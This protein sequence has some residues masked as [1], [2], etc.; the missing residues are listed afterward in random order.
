MKDSKTIILEILI[1]LA[2]YFNNMLGMVFMF[3][4]AA[5]KL[6]IQ[7]GKNSIR[8]LGLMIMALP[9]AYI[10][11]AGIGMHQLFSWYNVFLVCFLILILHSYSWK[12]P[13]HH[14]A[15][16]QLII[17]LFLLL[18]N[19]PYSDDI[20]QTFVEIAQ[21]FVMLIPIVMLHSVKRSLQI[22]TAEA[23]KLISMYVD[24]C[25]ATS[26]AMLVQYIFYFFVHIQVGII[27]VYGGGRV[28]C[29]CLFKGASILPV[30]IG[31]GMVILFLDM[32]SYRI[33][34][35]GILKM[36]VLFLAVI[37]NSSR[38]ALFALII[39]LAFVCLRQLV[40]R[41]GLK[42][43][44]VT[45]TGFFVAA[46]GVYY[47]ISLRRGL[48]GFLDANGRVET[49]INGI[50]IW[51]ADIKNFLIGG[52]LSDGLW[53]S[54]MEPHNFP[55]QTL[56]QSGLIISLIIFN[57]IFTYLWHNRRNRNK[58]AIWFVLLS[59]FL[60]TDFYANAFTTVIFILVDLYGVSN[61]DMAGKGQI[62]FL[63]NS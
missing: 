52:G 43:L 30:F 4:V 61:T 59:G 62:Q 10:G 8:F 3:G 38:T 9:M 56:A 53:T 15:A 51:L 13:I 58:Y 17:I 45:L 63:R 55:I 47:I 24:V 1:I 54:M 50:S 36:M 35:T 34:I 6:F 12:V 20:K 37:L 32:L 46:G 21:I 2:Y 7:H 5:W 18:L 44:L 31:I 40:K 16:V 26:I 33:T 22:E 48:T 42:P 39:V 19:L 11:I 57:M 60:V 41:P 25:I 29:Q 14:I 49:W 28:S 27:E 23:Q